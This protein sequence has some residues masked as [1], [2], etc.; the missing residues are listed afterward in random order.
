LHKEDIQEP[1]VKEAIEQLQSALTEVEKTCSGI[2][3]SMVHS[4]MDALQQQ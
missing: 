2:T 4:L 1:K 3:V